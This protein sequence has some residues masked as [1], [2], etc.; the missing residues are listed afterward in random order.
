M[1]SILRLVVSGSLFHKVAATFLKHLYPYVKSRVFGTLYRV[2][3]PQRHCWPISISKFIQIPTS[4]PMKSIVRIH[5]DR[6]PFM[7]VNAGCSRPVLYGLNYEYG[8]PAR[9]QISVLFAVSVLG[10]AY[11]EH[12][13]KADVMLAWHTPVFCEHPSWYT[14]L[15]DQYYEF[16]NNRFLIL[17]LRSS[18]WSEKY[19]SILQR[20]SL[21][22][23][24]RHFS[25]LSEAGYPQ[26]SSPGALSEDNELCLFLVQHKHIYTHPDSDI[27]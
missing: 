18:S 23:L 13:R 26:L 4:C 11:G 21:T 22:V 10:R 3:Q 27:S 2:I 24:R 25:N 15:Y 9:L 6:V 7:T 8:W 1:V 14:A 5:Q 20:F 19:Q 12:R 16:G 17:H